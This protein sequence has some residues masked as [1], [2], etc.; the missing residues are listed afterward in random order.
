MAENMIDIAG[1]SQDLQTIEDFVNLPADSEV[2]PR[3]LPSVNV[4]TLAGARQAIFEAGG[5]PA[6]P[7]ATKALMT[8]SALIDGDYAQVT[9]G[10]ADNGL[11]LKIAG[12]WVKSAY[13]PVFKS[14]VD[15][16]PLFKPRE[17][18][19][20]EDAD[21]LETGIYYINTTVAAA[22]VLHMPDFAGEDKLGVLVVYKARLIGHQI[23]TPYRST[24][25]IKRTGN[26]GV[27][28][29]IYNPWVKDVGK[30]SIDA[31]QTSI[32]RKASIN[33]IPN[34]SLTAG[35]SS[36]YE[37]DLVVE[38]GFNTL[39]MQTGSATIVEYDITVDN[40]YLK[41][42]DTL[43]LT[44]EGFTDVASASSTKT[45]SGDIAVLL[46]NSAGSIITPLAIS[47]TTTVNTW[48][49]LTIS[50]QIT[51]ETTAVRVRFVHRNKGALTKFRNAVLSSSNPA[52]HAVNPLKASSGQA[53]Q[54]SN[55]VYVKKTGSDTNLG[56]QVNPYL[57]IQKAVGAIKDG[58]HIIVL[59]SEDY[60][61]AVTINSF[62]H[63]KISATAGNRVNIFGSD[64]L[65][66]TKTSG[67]TKVYQAPL[68]AKPTGLGGV[69]G[70]PMIFEWGTK[71]KPIIESERHF[72]Q[73]GST[74]R[75][76]YTEMLEAASIAELDTVNGKWFWQDGVIYLSATDGGD[77][78]AKRYEARIRPVLT[79]TN[80]TLEL[81][82][83]TSWFSSS[84][85]MRSN[86]LSVTRHDC[87]SFGS[88]H[89]GFA[90]N[91]NMT[92][93]YRDE[94]AGNGNDGINLTLSPSLLANPEVNN[95]ITA[96]YFDPYSHDNGDDGI[97]CHFRSDATVYGGLFE[98]NTKADVVHVT[99]SQCVCYN[100][101][102]RGTESGF[103][104]MMTP[105]NDSER[106]KSVFRCVNTKSTDNNYA[107]RQDDDAVL[108]C[109]NTL[110][111]NP[112]LWGYS[113]NGTGSLI[114]NDARYI[115][116]A[117][118]AKTG[119]VTVNNSNALV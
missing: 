102:S 99:G 59:D 26:G 97:S 85:G 64:K 66:V 73:R 101:V 50:A 34:P 27:S 53:E 60:R 24:T 19:G 114:A 94:G 23:F 107:Y 98:Y 117:A 70:L 22:G 13:S 106:V 83:V 32:D 118:K 110:A 37:A 67:F 78:T 28:G 76:P 16:N 54:N 75:L 4:G 61:E 17:L 96:I 55:T 2:Y 119:S 81:V 44:A 69:R 95:R 31:L 20:T 77:A 12:T 38:D 11:Y 113:Q 112:R 88:H 93:S 5:L 62:A 45:E 63:V 108:I 104:A 111:V 100:T 92:T 42:G 36:K 33:L 18:T 86:A 79:H 46:L 82:R 87:M 57:T 68:A 43:T 105:T 52:T 72:L 47:S 58:G 48:Q 116:D 40:N 41:V 1:A 71:S 7:F 3:L 65:V 115:G 91:A 9:D 35:G 25:S 10:G 49:K 90:D 14:Y 56:T 109:D 21:L 89:N 84:Y 29:F 74:H 80:G 103:Y 30:Q 8:A 6:T 51:A 15:D 39:V